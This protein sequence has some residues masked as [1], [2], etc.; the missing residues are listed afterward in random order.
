[1]RIACFVTL[2]MAACT[3]GSVDSDADDRVLIP[4]A[5]VRSL[6]EVKETH[7]I[8]LQV[9]LRTTAGGSLG[10]VVGGVSSTIL[11]GNPALGVQPGCSMGT[12]LA[13][14]ARLASAVN[15]QWSEQMRRAIL[16]WEVWRRSHKHL[17]L[18]AGK[19]VKRHFA[20][21]QSMSIPTKWPKMLATKTR[22]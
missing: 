4:S 6:I 16:A 15:N 13:G 5:E 14:I 19:D 20:H 1:M 2:C 7:Q 22:T 10:C 12:L 8:A 17:R 21:A 18:A 9:A 11:T 3:F